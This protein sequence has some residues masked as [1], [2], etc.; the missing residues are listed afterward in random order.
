MAKQQAAQARIKD[1]AAQVTATLDSNAT[2]WARHLVGTSSFHTIETDLLRVKF[3]NK[4][5][6]P[7]QVELKKYSRA[8]SSLV[9]VIED[10]SDQFSF[11]VLT[12]P[13]QSTASADLFFQLKSAQQD[14]SGNHIIVYEASG[15]TGESIQQEYIVHP[16]SYLIDFNLRLQGTTSMIPQ[17]NLQLQWNVAAMQQEKDA[18]YER[19]QSQLILVE[20]GEYDYFNLFSNDTESFDNTVQWASIKQRFFNATLINKEKFDKAKFEWTTPA[21]DSSRM[22]VAVKANFEK[23]FP[24]EP[25]Q[26][27]RCSFTLVRM[28]INCFDHWVLRTWIRS[29]TLDRGP[30]LLSVRLTSIS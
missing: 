19:E 18:R 8:D 22:I 25:R 14:A 4:G 24:Q 11:P 23:S 1:S 2:G 6:Q 16:A 12:A 26:L 7:V 3:S 20:N 29:L 27:C 10:G 13:N 15:A 21:D 28:I 9:S 17:Q 5:G 30:M